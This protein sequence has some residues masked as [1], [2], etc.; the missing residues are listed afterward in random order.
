MI[1]QS[2]NEWLHTQESSMVHMAGWRLRK[3]T[4]V[5]VIQSAG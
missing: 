4:L 2:Q 3:V 1:A 5:A